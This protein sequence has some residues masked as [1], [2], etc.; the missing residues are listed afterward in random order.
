MDLSDREPAGPTA[1]QGDSMQ[2]WLIVIDAVGDMFRTVTAAI[3]LITVIINC[4]GG[5]TPPASGG[6]I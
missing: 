5:G 4:R 1:Y 3:T 2:H 6:S